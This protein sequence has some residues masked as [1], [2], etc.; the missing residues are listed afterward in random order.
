MAENKERTEENGGELRTSYGEQQC[1]EELDREPNLDERLKEEKKVASEKLWYQFQNSASAVTALYKERERSQDGQVPLWLVFQNAATN[2]TKLYKDSIECHRRSLELGIKIGQQRKT[3]DIAAWAKKRRRFI[4]R[5]DLLAF[6]C[7]NSPPSRQRGVQHPRSS[8]D[9]SSPR[10]Y[11]GTSPPREQC[12]VDT[13]DELQPFRDALALHGLNG[14][15]ANVG[16]SQS[17]PH[18]RRRV[19]NSLQDLE[20]ILTSSQEARKRNTIET[21]P[22]SPSPKRSRYF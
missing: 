11:A 19:S 16:V 15:M 20:D 1:L 22:D 3:R 17:P 13:G 10:T 21:L 4:H 7:G 14:A 2:V 6:L 18:S 12:G 9:R 8:S 5:E